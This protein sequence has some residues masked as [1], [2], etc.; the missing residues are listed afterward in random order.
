MSA[1]I[2]RPLLTE[3]ANGDTLYTGPIGP[4]MAAAHSERDVKVEHPSERG[5]KTWRVSLHDSPNLMPTT[6]AEW[7]CAATLEEAW[8]YALGAFFGPVDAEYSEDLLVRIIE[9]HS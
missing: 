9:E 2:Q 3:G 8:R 7:G 6:E 1:V 5:G 4:G